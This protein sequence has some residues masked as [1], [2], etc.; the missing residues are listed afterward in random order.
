MGMLDQLRKTRETKA[1]QTNTPPQGHTLAE[2]LQNENSNRLFGMFLGEKGELDLGKRIGE[3]KLEEA[4]IRTLEVF[5]K[6]FSEKIIK[7]EKVER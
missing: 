5:R 7:V 6:E 4:D 3:S 2:I 1:G